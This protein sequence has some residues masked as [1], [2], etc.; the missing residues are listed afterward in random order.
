M[1]LRPPTR[2]SGPWTS[3]DCPRPIGRWTWSPFTFTGRTTSDPTSVWLTPNST[4]KFQPVRSCI[5][6]RHRQFARKSLSVNGL[7][8]LGRT[9]SASDQGSTVAVQASTASVQASS[10]SVHAPSATDKASSASVQARRAAAGAPIHASERLWPCPQVSSRPPPV[11]AVSCTRRG[12]SV[13][14]GLPACLIDRALL[15]C[16]IMIAVD[17]LTALPPDR[18]RCRTPA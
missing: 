8:A 9:S 13:Q 6:S 11:T 12:W 5:S 7:G 14:A 1:G 3:D 4:K 10:G 18:R 15:V 2:G 17:G 16:K